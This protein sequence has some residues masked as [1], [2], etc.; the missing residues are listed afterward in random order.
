M[1]WAWA[2]VSGQCAGPG[3]MSTPSF[4]RK[5]RYCTHAFHVFFVLINGSPYALYGAS[6]GLWQ[7]NSLSLFTVLPKRLS[8]LV[9]LSYLIA[10]IDLRIGGIWISH[11][12]ST[13]D[14]L[15]SGDA[16]LE[17]GKNVRHVTHLFEVVFGRRVKMSK[18]VG[19]GWPQEEIMYTQEDYNRLQH[20]GITSNALPWTTY[21]LK[22]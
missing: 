10:R 18:R 11:L 8:K 20:G 4:E 16:L 21:Q 9:G 2:R 5:W 1:V 7:C 12:P 15:L 17:K 22:S 3:L 14:M 6:I 13:D 19:E